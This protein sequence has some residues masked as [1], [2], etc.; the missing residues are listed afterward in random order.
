MIGYVGGWFLRLPNKIAPHNQRVSMSSRPN[1]ITEAV[2]AGAAEIAAARE[3][4][5]GQQVEM[6]VLMSDRTGAALDQV[7]ERAGRGRPAGAANLSTRQMRQYLLAR[8]ISPLESLMRMAMHTPATLASELRCEPLE[9]AEYLRKVWG[10]L[11]PYLHAKVQ[12]TDD[13]G[14]AVPTVIVSVGGAMPVIGAG[15]GAA[16]MPWDDDV[17]DVHNQELSVDDADASHGEASH[18][19]AKD[20]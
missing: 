6:F 17:I 3:K 19:T 7:R 13:E 15:G 5:A 11:A 16:R 12:P 10:D 8:G 20:E 1:V 9:A 18:E 4:A 14:R 2:K